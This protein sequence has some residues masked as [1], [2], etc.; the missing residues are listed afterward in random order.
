MKHLLNLAETII[1]V[2]LA[3]LIV[4]PEIVYSCL[5]R[6]RDRLEDMAGEIR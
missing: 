4:T 3:V 5:L 1:I 2:C 6:L